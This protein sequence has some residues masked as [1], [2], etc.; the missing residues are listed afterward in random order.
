[1]NMENVEDE[2]HRERRIACTAFMLAKEATDQLADSNV[3]AD[4]FDSTIF[5][6]LCLQRKF[7]LIFHPR[8]EIC[9]PP[10]ERLNGVF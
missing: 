3:C 10:R 6:A 8:Q 9:A 2:L 5:P 4:L 1:M 7:G